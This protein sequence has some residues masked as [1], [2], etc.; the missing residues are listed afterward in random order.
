[1]PCK[2][3]FFKQKLKDLHCGIRQREQIQR[4]NIILFSPA[5]S[6]L[7]IVEVIHFIIGS[8]KVP[9]KISLVL[10]TLAL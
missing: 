10:K 3:V 7:L 1:M 4:G 6:D 8:K 9:S 5:K 2:C